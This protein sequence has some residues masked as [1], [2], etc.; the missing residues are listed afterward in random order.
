MGL[1]QR[2][3]CVCELRVTISASRASHERRKSV[4]WR[5]TMK[6]RVT[7]A[8]AGLSSRP[9]LLVML[10]LGLALAGGS[11]ADRATTIPAALPLQINVVSNRADL[12]SG[13]DAL[14]QIVIPTG[15]SPS[16]V[17]VTLGSKD[18]TS[19]FAVRPNALYEGL[20]TGL[21]KGANVL[22]ASA[23]GAGSAS[24]TITNHPNGGPIF[25]GPQIQPWPCLAGA[26]D[27][28]C[29]QPVTYQYEYVDVLTGQFAAYD[30]NDP[31][32][33]GTV[34]TTTTD[35]GN[36]VP[37]IVRVETGAQDRGQY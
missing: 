12:I 3:Q 16:L 8:V 10:I 20:V 25:S 24:I 37:F 32:T 7:S 17:K 35:Q 36:T 4:G 6:F 5:R 18:I 28:Q 33:P 27:A 21:V 15:V 13:G 11:G 1:T 29:N 23:T 26:T 19:E 30:P 2:P 9:I 22:K 31:P 34:A 14:V